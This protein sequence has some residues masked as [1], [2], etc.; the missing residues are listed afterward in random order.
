MGNSRE[1]ACK[2]WP[3]DSSEKGT[4]EEEEKLEANGFCFAE[5]PSGDMYY[6]RQT[7]H[8]IHLYSS[9]EWDSAEAPIDCECLEEYFALFRPRPRT[10]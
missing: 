8:I 7:G 3:F 5:D 9:G 10:R 4:Q 6:W 2:Q 1:C